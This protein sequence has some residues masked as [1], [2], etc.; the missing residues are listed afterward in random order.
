M[1][2]YIY[3]PSTGGVPPSAISVANLP[4]SASDGDWYE[5]GGEAFTY[6]KPDGGPG[7]WVPSWLYEQATGYV[8]N[9]SGDAFW[10]LADP[11]LATIT[12]RGWATEIPGDGTVTKASDS[13]PLVVNSGTT[14]NCRI[15]FAPTSAPTKSVL[16]V[17]LGTITGSTDSHTII[18]YN[19]G[20]TQ[21][22]LS[23][24]DGSAG[25][26]QWMASS[27][28]LSSE[29][30]NMATLSAGDWLMIVMDRSAA[31]SLLLARKL[32][33]RTAIVA[34]YSDCSGTGTP[35]RAQVFTNSTLGTHEIE[36]D[37]IH[38]IAYT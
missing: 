18:G 16:L 30:G 22:R 5:V 4:A 2:V 35:A 19:D 11:D 12:G 23:V 3:S 27:S 1:S 34:E 8:S 7:V 14:S 28:P 33:E 31:N 38:W 6:Y 25:A 29:K 17:K 9:A 21:I 20:S 10:T 24:S 13:D 26:A 36:V 15:G 37:E 32:G